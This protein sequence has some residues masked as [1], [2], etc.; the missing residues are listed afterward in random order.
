MDL[1]VRHETRYEYAAPLG[2]GLL[3]LRLTPRSNAVQEVSGWTVRVEGAEVETEFADQHGNVT[4]LAR[5]D[6]GARRLAAVAEGAA[7]TSLENGVTGPHD[8]SAPLWLYRRTTPLTRAGPGVAALPAPSGG[9]V[10]ELHAL[11]AAIL[12]AMPWTVG[13]TEAVTPAED[14]LAGGA[15]VCQDHV[16]VFLA[17]ARLAGVPA[18]YVSGYLRMDDRDDQEAGHAWAEAWVDGLGWTGFDVSNG[19]SPDGRYLTLATGLDAREAAPVKGI[20]LGGGHEELDVTLTV[21]EAAAQQ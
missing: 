18:R 5:I 21:A 4:T 1:R 11:S 8:A 2:G 9:A 16:H 12:A 3:R 13:A 14:A 17:A 20:V 10:A 6:P 19:H 15:G 7:R